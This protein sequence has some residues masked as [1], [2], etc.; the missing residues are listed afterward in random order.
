MIQ[1]DVHAFFLFFTPPPFFFITVIMLLGRC[2]IVALHDPF[3]GLEEQQ[4]P[5][6]GSCPAPANHLRKPV[7]TAPMRVN[8][9]QTTVDPTCPPV[10]HLLELLHEITSKLQI[11]SLNRVKY[12]YFLN[13]MS[14]LLNQ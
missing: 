5:G 14:N 6:D 12:I 2:L 10:R 11:P 7:N 4:E 1:G 9:G 8:E 3:S 13:V